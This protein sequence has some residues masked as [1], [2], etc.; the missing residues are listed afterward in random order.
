[1]VFYIIGLG[2]GDEKDIS[3]KGLEI[4]KKCD[5]IYLEHYTSILGVQKERL[6]EFYGRSIIMADREMCEEGID[7]IL[8][9][10]SDKPEK[11][12]AFLVVGDPF[13]AT[14]HSDVQ[15]RAIELGIKVEIVHNASIV[16]AIG[17]TGMQVYR[18]GE[19]VS[20]PFFTEKWRPY[21]FFEKIKH[22][23]DMGL[24]TLCL[25]DIKVKER[26]DENI[27]KNKKI[28]EPPRFMSCQVAVEQILEAEK[29]L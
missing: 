17:C 4:V 9:D 3:V 22:N 25:L 28:F 19:I 7:H 15:L 2:L 5:E 23:R 13:C 11:N 26:T 14:T 21:S 6:E 29:N 8:E 10:L 18:F 12:V 16:N 24:H 1:M 20:I 27:L